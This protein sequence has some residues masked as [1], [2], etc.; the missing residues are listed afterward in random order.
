MKRKQQ[1]E[2]ERTRGNNDLHVKRTRSSN[3]ISAEVHHQS[4]D[5]ISSNN[6]IASQS[7]TGEKENIIGSEDSEEDREINLNNNNATL[8]ES[9][10]KADRSPSRPTL[11]PIKAQSQSTPKSSRYG[12]KLFATPI[13]VKGITGTDET[14]RLRRNIDR[15]AR[16][17]STRT[18]IERTVLGLNS[19]NDDEEE[20]IANQIYDSDEDGEVRIANGDTIQVS[21][22]LREP[23][24]PS[25]RGRGQLK[26]TKARQRSLTPPQDLTAHELYFSQNR[27]GR[28]KT[29]NSNLSSLAL[30]DHEEYFSLARSYKDQ[31]EDDMNF[32]QDVH[33]K[34][35][36]QWQF[37]LGQD[38]NICVYGW[39]S[40]RSLLLKFAEHIYNTM[41][42]HSRQ[43]IVVV[44][45]YVQNLT[46]RELLNTIACS[47]SGHGTKIGSQPAEMLENLTNILDGDKSQRVTLII[48]SLDG[49]ALRRP[50]SQTILSRLSS[51]PQVHL[52]V[53]VDH[54]SF[55]LLWDSSLRSAFNFLFH[56]CTTF[57]PYTVEVDVV[58]E[59][60][61]LLG[62]SGRKVGGKGGVSFV[63]KSL[64]ENAKNLFRVLV[65]EQ[66]ATMDE[67][68]VGEH[69]DDDED[70]VHGAAS[71]KSEPGVEYRV[72][73]QKAVEEFICSNEMNFRT[74]LKEFH[75]HQMIESRKDALGTEVLF[76]P[77]RKEEL[78]NILEDIVS[79]FLTMARA[80][81]KNPLIF[82]LGATGTGKSQ[83]AIDLAKRFNG[84]IINGDAVQMYEGL[85]IITNKVTV[86]EQNGVPHHLLGFIPLDAET[87]TVGTFKDRASQI[88]QEIRSRG[89]LPIVVGGTH[90]YTQSLLFEHELVSSA[91][92]SGEGQDNQ[93]LSIEEISKRFPILDAP[94]EQILDRLREVDPIM[95]AQWHPNDRRKIQTSLQIFLT[96]G[97]KASDIYKEQKETKAMAQASSDGTS[98]HPDAFSIGSPL[99]FWVHAKSDTLKSRLDKR[100]DKMIDVGLLDEVK[101]METIRQEFIRGGIDLDLSRGI[102]A[103]IGWKE[104]E[105]Y[106][107]ALEWEDRDPKKLDALHDDS[108]EKMK[109]ATRQYAKR[110]IRWISLKLI[111]S[112]VQTNALDRLYLLD[113]TDVSSWLENVSGPAVDITQEFLLGSKLPSP[114]E[115]SALAGE[116]LNPEKPLQH[117]Q[118]K[119]RWVPKKCEI[120]H[121]VVMTE[122]QWQVHSTTRAHR[123]MVKKLQKNGVTG[124]SCHDSERGGGTSSFAT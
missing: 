118:S 93:Q 58:D 40:K 32:L 79:K 3:R 108:L 81:P 35:F 80:A 14:P 103:S 6:K 2:K 31:H 36:N 54:P 84:E 94:T 19:D 25:K 21:E 27:P 30:L 43:R 90:Y 87:W 92:G 55:H 66:L 5:V 7:P 112:L 124:R 101:S 95:A 46:I 38:L 63:L 12:D 73:Y 67:T 23:S 88:I 20:D 45:G 11:S 82:V 28:S 122:G 42:D 69:N 120:C 37:E 13:K 99:L 10:S 59:V 18:L 76:V 115:M 62:R 22:D 64:P 105:L 9:Q 100:V 65:G 57:L 104:F 97:K 44:N 56:D 110:Q 72:L 83:L 41:T 86:E 68:L 60:H 26:G 74:L 70:G 114:S 113:G 89:R 48:H 102:W 17:K 91:K 53:S 111:P 15:S 116:F 39:G 106:L 121:V 49:S 96:S 47:I 77:F 29:A 75:D 78:E 117:S 123:R 61:E 98:D 33:A 4:E 34:S 1:D 51:H 52:V 107:R 16:R 109:A 24:T 119:A 8:P 50:A 71:R 85:P